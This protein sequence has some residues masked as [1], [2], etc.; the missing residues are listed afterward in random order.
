MKHLRKE[1]RIEDLL[2]RE[3]ALGREVAF[4]QAR[5]NDGEVYRFLV[6]AAQVGLDPHPKAGAVF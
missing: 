1:L 3:R 6:I 2:D 5:L 4:R